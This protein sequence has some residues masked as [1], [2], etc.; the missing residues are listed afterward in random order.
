MTIS[1]LVLAAA[2]AL[3]LGAQAQAA[4]VTDTAAEV[5]LYAGDIV[6]EAYAPGSDDAALAPVF[7]GIYGGLGFSPAFVLSL[8]DTSGEVLYGETDSFSF[9]GA[10]V[11]SFLFD[12][13]GSAAAL[14]GDSVTVTLTFAGLVADP[15]GASADLYD[16]ATMSIASGVPTSPVPLPGSIVLLG[17]AF[18]GTRLL[19]RRKAA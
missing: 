12:V 17:S 16:T 2:L 10:H 5:T 3:G 4:T 15:F 18:L 6:A 19:R 13:T 7:A 14:F 1:K 11:L 8:E 9:D